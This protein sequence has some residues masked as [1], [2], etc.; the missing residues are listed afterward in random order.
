MNFFLAFLPFC[1]FSLFLGRRPTKLLSPL[2][3][4][5][6]AEQDEQTKDYQDSLNYDYSDDFLENI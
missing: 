6:Q 2:E 3:Q 1:L 5:Q 4:R